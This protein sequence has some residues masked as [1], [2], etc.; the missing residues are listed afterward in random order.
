MPSDN[1][2]RQPLRRKD[3]LFKTTVRQ[4]NADGKD[5]GGNT[6]FAISNDYLWI[7]FYF[8]VPLAW[9]RD[10]EPLGP[11]FVVTWENRLENREESAAFCIL[12]SGWGYNTKKRDDLVRRLRDAAGKAGA[13]PVSAQIAAA[14]GMTTCQLCGALSPRVFDFSWFTSFL[15][16][17]ISI[18]DRRVLCLPHAASRL[19]AVTVYN[20]II[21]NLGFGMFVSPIVSLGNILQ[22]RRTGAI[23]KPETAFWTALVF[24]PYLLMATLVGWSIWYAITF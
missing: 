10:I 24:W 23:T 12:R 15:A 18:P 6:D 20:L 8:S 21:G 14:P 16:F 22:V 1:P 19:R 3:V 4:A 7:A 5:A 17:A 13:G 9:I 11:G 2:F